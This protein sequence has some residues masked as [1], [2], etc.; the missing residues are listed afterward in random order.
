MI[1]VVVVAVLAAIAYPSYMSSVRKGRRS[2]AVSALTSLQQAQERWR[3]NN[4]QYSTS[5]TDL[6]GATTTPNGYYAISIDSADAADYVLTAQAAAGTSQAADD[7]C[8][9]MRLQLVGGNVFYGG[10]GSCSAPTASAKA[11]DPD[12][13]WAR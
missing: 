3:A 12:R 6:G 2:E 10:C 13:C 7:K 1:V 4:Q 9:V 8:K 11:S 5:V